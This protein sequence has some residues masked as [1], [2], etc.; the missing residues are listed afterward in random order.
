MAYKYAYVGSQIALTPIAG[1]GVSSK[2][3]V[4][5]MILD[6]TAEGEFK[7][8]IKDEV[9]F[10]V[11]YPATLGTLKTQADGAITAKYPGATPL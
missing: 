6:D 2:A 8:G 7:T 11:N 3:T 9:F 1:G 10:D 5:F 4:N